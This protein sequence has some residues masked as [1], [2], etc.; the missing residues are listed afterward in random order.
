MTLLFIENR[1]KTFFF[2][3]LVNLLLKEHKIHWIVQNKQF[4]PKNGKLHKLKKPTKKTTQ[5]TNIDLK[6]IIESDRIVN[7]FKKKNLSYFNNYALQIEALIDEIKPDFVFGESTLFH[8]LITIEL[9]KQKKILFLHPSSCRYPQNRFSFYLNDSVFPYL[10]SNETL[11]DDLANDIINTISNRVSKPDY[12]KPNRFSKSKIYKN[13]LKI[14]K[15]FLYG[16]RYN[17]PHP[18]VKLSAEKKKAKIIKLWDKVAITE[19]NSSTFNLVYPLHMQPEANIDVWGRGFSN[20]LEN[21]KNISNELETGQV[22]YLKPNP[23]SKHE[24]TQELIHFASTTKNVKILHHNVSMDV[25]FDDVD[26]FI[27]VNGTIALECVFSNKP[28]L[29]LIKGFFN[30]AQNCL[31]LNSFVN[32]QSFISR[33][34]TNNFPYLEPNQKIEFLNL[35]TRSSYEGLISDPY[36]SEKCVSKE[37]IALI[38]KAFNDILIKQNDK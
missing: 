20:Q 32:L 19:L 8:E 16:E 14:I 15:S 38:H 6:K 4:L 1:Y 18:V 11:S 30:N 13:K 12:M 21:I 28:V 3:E 10:G 36:Y 22:L 25:I 37:N 33:V 29:T 7:Y 27:T 17:T 9:C 31:Y 5:K 23:K 35:L 34:C 2:D 26:L 24:L